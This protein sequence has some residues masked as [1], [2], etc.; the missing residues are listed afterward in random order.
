MLLGNIGRSHSL[1]D[2]VGL[3]CRIRK[4]REDKAPRSQLVAGIWRAQVHGVDLEGLLLFVYS[5]FIL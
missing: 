2:A 1:E 3:N 5:N 4:A